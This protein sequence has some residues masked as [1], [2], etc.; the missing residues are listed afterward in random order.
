[1]RVINALRN[2]FPEY[3]WK[4][5]TKSHIWTCSGG[6]S[7]IPQ[8][9]FAPKYDGDDDSFITTYM[10]SDTRDMVLMPFAYMNFLHP[11][12]RSK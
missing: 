1:M 12:S 7:I 8:A 5:D 11:N 3:T 4:Y 6:F 10:R 2:R 9:K